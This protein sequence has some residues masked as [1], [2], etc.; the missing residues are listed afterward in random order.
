MMG[1]FQI[2][3]LARYVRIVPSKP[4]GRL[5]PYLMGAAFGV[6]WSPC[7]GPFLAGVLGLASQESTVW[8]GMALLAL[9][10]LGLGIPFV[11]S[12]LAFQHVVRWLR[13]AR[14]VLGIVPRLG[15]AVLVVMGILLFSGQL[16]W[17]SGF[18]TQLFGTGLT[19]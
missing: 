4:G 6:G 9:Y 3:L 16:L 13:Q 8:Q 10:A 11:V 19:L 14:P 2:P 17:L 1:L 5:G 7:I 18:L 12:A 15:G